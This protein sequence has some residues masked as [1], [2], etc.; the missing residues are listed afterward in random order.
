MSIGRV[1]NRAITAIRVNPIVILGLALAIG[2][3]PGLVLTFL[4]GAYAGAA[5]SDFSTGSLTGLY[6]MLGISVLISIVIG[7]LVQ[8]ALTRATVSASEG[9]KTSFGENLSTGLRVAL[10]LIGLGII[11][12]IGVAIGMVLLVV[13]GIILALMWS[14]AAPA[15]V[16]EREGV[17]AALRRSSQLTK[18]ARWKILGLF[19]VVVIAYWLLSLVVSVVGIS[20]YSAGDPAGLTAANAIGSVVLGTLM[21]A[22]TGTIQ[23]ALYVELRQWKE[24]TSVEH[25][26]EIF[27]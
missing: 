24:G 4:V 9:R 12:A 27:A 7:A 2:A 10:P 6:V 5:V 23:P 16:V 25:L 22:A 3:L 15:L 26:E 17:F 21:N 19:L 13:P 1:F 20:A 18:G 14:V 11:I 8:G